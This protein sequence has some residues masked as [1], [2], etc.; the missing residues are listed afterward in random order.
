MTERLSTTYKRTEFTTS[1]R[2]AADARCNDACEGCGKPLA[3]VRRVYDH[4]WPQRLGGASDL[5]NCQVLCDDGPDSCNQRKTHGMDLPGIAAR[6]RHEKGR[7]ALDI[8]RPVRKPG[9]IVGRPMPKSSR[10]IPN[11]PFH[12]KPRTK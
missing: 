6:K 1:V 7:L 8:D 2:R 12:V 5:A 10:K 9:K 11:R 4:R 3:G